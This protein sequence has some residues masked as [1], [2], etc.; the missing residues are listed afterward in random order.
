MKTLTA[1]TACIALGVAAAFAVAPANA[2]AKS[3]VV[4]AWTHADL[5]SKAGDLSGVTMHLHHVLNCLVGP[6]QGTARSPTP[7]TPPR[8]NRSGRPPAR[9]ARA[10]PPKTSPARKRRPRMSPRC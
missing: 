2:D 10:S 1:L 6:M 4:T 5:A 7:K 3:E 9:H 8:K